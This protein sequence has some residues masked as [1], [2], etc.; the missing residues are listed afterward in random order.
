MTGILN[1]IFYMM[2]EMVFSLGFIEDIKEG[3]LYKFIIE[4]NEGELLYKADPYAFYAEVKPA[5]A[6]VT[7]DIEGYD[8]KDKEM[9]L[10]SRQKHNHMEKPL[11]IYEV[12]LG[13]WR[14]HEDGSYYTYTEMAKELVDYVKEM[15]YTHV[16]IMPVMEHPFDGSWGYQITGYFAPTS[17]Y[18]TPNRVYAPCRKFS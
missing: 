4:T 14:C 2:M 3:D 9:E 6:S 10:N 12:H 7:T 5:T 8:W 16:E 17:T 15:G 11:N 1:S 13:S 18:G